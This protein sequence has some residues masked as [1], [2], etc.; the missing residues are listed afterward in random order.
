MRG[1]LVAL[2]L[3]LSLEGL[4]AQNIEGAYVHDEMDNIKLYLSEDLFLFI[5][6]HE[7]SHLALFHC[8]DTLAFGYW[9]RD[10]NVSSFIK[11]YTNPMQLASLI[12]MQVNE[13]VVESTDSTYFLIR[14]PIEEVHEKYNKEND[15]ARVLYYTISVETN[16]TQIDYQVNLARFYSNTIV[17]GLPKDVFVKSFEI[18]AHPVNSTFG[19]RPNM[20]PN[21]VSTM[22]YEVT[23]PQ[24][25]QFVIDIP[26]LTACYLSTLRLNG[27]FVKVLSKNELEWDGHI[28]TKKK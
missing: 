28:Y 10:E 7:T 22:R 11:L 9:E 6:T 15:R 12:E 2:L 13:Q 16:R 24:S 25:N 4:V 17:L 19:W 18:T 27:D 5:D 14:N 3:S 26:E 1:L 8:S 23:N 20:P 21:Y